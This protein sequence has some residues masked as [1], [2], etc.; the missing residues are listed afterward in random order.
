MCNPFEV[1]RK[2]AHRVAAL[3]TAQFHCR[4][5]FSEGDEWNSKDQAI[6]NVL[7]VLDD[8]IVE[9]AKNLVNT[10]RAVDK[11]IKKMRDDARQQVESEE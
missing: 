3:C 6:A 1:R 11:H 9:A 8:L 7:D 2:A 5:Q 10:D 4:C